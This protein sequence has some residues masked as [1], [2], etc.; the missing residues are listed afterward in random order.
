MIKWAIAAGAAIAGFSFAAGAYVGW[1]TTL[2]VLDSV[3][4]RKVHSAS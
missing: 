3:E 1:K 4:R 2:K